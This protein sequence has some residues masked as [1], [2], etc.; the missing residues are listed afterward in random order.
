MKKSTTAK[1][2]IERA[3]AANGF[4]PAAA[5]HRC[6][7]GVLAGRVPEGDGQSGETRRSHRLY[8]RPAR[9]AD[10]VP[11]GG[12]VAGCGLEPVSQWRTHRPLPQGMDRYSAESAACQIA[13]TDRT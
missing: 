10:V 5:E 11:A 13:L 7:S 12:A 6:S 1:V 3:C 9:L 4:S 8:H 2:A